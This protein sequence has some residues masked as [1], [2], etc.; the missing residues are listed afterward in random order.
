MDHYALVSVLFPKQFNRNGLMWVRLPS[1]ALSGNSTLLINNRKH[2]EVIMKNSDKAA[3]KIIEVLVS[4]VGLQLSNETVATSMQDRI[5][6][7]SV[8]LNKLAE[9]MESDS[10]QIPESLMA[11]AASCVIAVAS[12]VGVEDCA[13]TDQSLTVNMEDAAQTARE[14]M[15]QRAKKSGLY[16]ASVPNIDS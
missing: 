6:N 15:I 13:L 1:W 8:E 16:I 7:V 10:E 11:V 3:L 5:L 12:M 9:S 14:L 4:R 2:Y